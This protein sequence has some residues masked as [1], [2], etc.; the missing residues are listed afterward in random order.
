MVPGESR[1]QNFERSDMLICNALLP[2]GQVRDVTTDEGRIVALGE[3]GSLSVPKTDV[4]DIEGALLAPAF[5]EGHVHLDKTHFGAELVPHEGAPDVQTRIAVERTLRHKVS[6][7]VE[8]RARDLIL[9][10]LSFGT[11]RI[12][13]HV[14]IDSDI[15]LAN[16]HA[17]LAVREQ[18]RDIVDI[19]LVAFPQS[20]IVRDPGVADL[21]DAA[22]AAG[23]DLVGGLD[24]HGIDGDIDGHLD[25]V[26]GL[27]ARHGKSID[28]HLH[29]GGAIG[30]GELRDIA[31]RTKA[32][33][34]NDRVTV[35]H[36]FSLGMVDELTFGQTAAQLA[37][38]GISIM[39]SSPP[40]VPV[41]PV[42]RLRGYG[43]NVFAA[44]DN[45][46]DC[47]SPFGN[48]DLL[49]RASIVCQR[50]EFFANEDIRGAFEMI[51]TAPA[52]ALSISPYG[53]AQ[54]DLSDLV[55]LDAPSVEEAV[56]NRARR[57]HVIRRGRLVV[58]DGE[59]LI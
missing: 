11:T 32:H 53:I 40:P 42:A 23:V 57:L 59:V 44:S 3:P 12:R 18:L 49:D 29:D 39:T 36:A 17:L 2:G 43:V 27:A 1:P 37:E 55:V 41:P 14:D 34:L 21:M 33:G 25:V 30:A 24:P 46:R 52:R 5:V 6:R 47:W 10:M 26:F 16:V 13:S 7:P 51:S 8:Q 54:G 48:G 9:R 45:I 50:Q 4:L 22:L 20:G 58:K 38:A 56:I 35:S 31:A 15:K 19:Q 28:I